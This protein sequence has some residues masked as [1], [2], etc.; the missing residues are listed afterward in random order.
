MTSASRN[1]QIRAQG[2]EFR[3][4]EPAD[5][6]A[7]LVRRGQNGGLEI[8]IA[9]LP[10]PPNSYDADCATVRRDG[11]SVSVFFGKRDSAAADKLRSRVEIRYGLLPFFERLCNEDMRGFHAKVKEFVTVEPGAFPTIL[12]AGGKEHS[13][14]ANLEYF[15]CV[16]TEASCDFY[17]ASVTRA[18]QGNAEKTELVPVLRVLTTVDTVY[19]LLSACFALAASLVDDPLAMKIK[20]SNKERSSA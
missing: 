2:G 5:G 1:R 16:L 20:A 19:H 13:D 4:S 3:Q 7:P 12:I 15:A 18:A 14:W 8:N 11:G 10:S 9:A 17:R 6:P